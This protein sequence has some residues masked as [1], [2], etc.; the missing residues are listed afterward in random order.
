M[1][2]DRMAR[3]N[4]LLRRELSSLIEQRVVPHIDALLTITGVKTAPDLRKALVFVS[5]MGEDAQC[6]AAFDILRHERARLQAE[7]STRVKLRYT[8]VLKFILDDTPAKA[9]RVHAILEELNL[10]DVPGEGA[11]RQAD[12]ADGETDE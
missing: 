1:T 9:D 12:G 3:V 8:P 10:S 5:L 6:K 4:E 7:V 2:F 11:A